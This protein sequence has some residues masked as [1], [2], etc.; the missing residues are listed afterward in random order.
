MTNH[1][2]RIRRLAV[3]GFATAAIGLSLLLP[4]T[5]FADSSSD[6]TIT[7]RR[8]FNDNQVAVQ[9][10]KSKAYQKS[11]QD[12]DNSNHSAQFGKLEQDQPNILKPEADAPAIN[13]AHPDVYSSA[14]NEVQSG[15]AKAYGNTT[16][17]G[18]KSEQDADA[19]AKGLAVAV[20]YTGDANGTAGDAYANGGNQYLKNDQETGDGGNSIAHASSVVVNK[21]DA[22]AINGVISGGGKDCAKGGPDGQD[23]HGHDCQ[24]GKSGS[25]KITAD[26]SATAGGNTGTATSTATSGTGGNSGS[27]SGSNSA[28]ANGGTA[29]PMAYGGSTGDNT[30]E[31]MLAGGTAV[32]GLTVN[33]TT[34]GNTT[35]TSGAATNSGS[36]SS[37]ATS[38][39]TQTATPTVTQTLNNNPI[40]KGTLDQSSWQL[41]KADQSSDQSAGN[42][43]TSCQCAGGS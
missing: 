11:E 5:A 10:A 34:S 25:S 37:G 28:W 33:A 32:N 24:K 13:I 15:D 29:A 42:S 2:G 7:L 4:A 12:A 21:S 38:N 20:N 39:L 18:I 17:I 23:N 3:S 22:D 9:L 8:S 36:A 1:P 19:S 30:A 35:A 6:P 26:P 40:L 14:K 16:V 27:N 43:Q 31:A 41:N